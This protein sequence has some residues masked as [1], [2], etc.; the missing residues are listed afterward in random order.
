M[1]TDLLL[2]VEVAVDLIT[3]REPGGRPAE[4]AVQLASAEDVRLWLYVG[5]VS[6]LEQ[7]TRQA[8]RNGKAAQGESGDGAGADRQARQA[9]D[10]LSKKVSWLAALSGEGPVFAAHEPPCQAQLLRA[11]ERLGDSGRLL[12]RDEAL[13]AA[14]PDRTM[15]PEGFLLQGAGG[16]APLPFIDLA[17]QQDRLRPELEENLHRVLHHGRYILGQEVAELE[18]RLADFA[19]VER[20]IGCASGTDA[21]LLALLAL[22]VGPGDAVF[23]SPFTF[24]AT[25]EV[26]SLLGA[27][28]VFVDIDPATLTI[29][30]EQLS[31]AVRSLLNPEEADYPLPQGNRP[32]KPKAVIPVD[33]FGVPAD[34]EGIRRTAEAFGLQI[35]EDAAQSLGAEYHGRKAGALADIGCTSFFP[36]KPLGAYGDA[37]A[38]FTDDPE[39][40]AVMDSLKVHGTGSERYAHD[41][42]GLNARLDSLQ[43]AV[44]LPKL[45]ILQE[46]VDSRQRVAATYSRLIRERE[47]PL[48]LPSVP[49]GCRSAWAQYSVLAQDRDSR[50]RMQKRLAEHSVPSAI[51]YPRPLHMQR[52]FA[53]LGYRPED[54]PVSL[55]MSSRIFSLP[56]HPYLDEPGLLRIVSALEG[57]PAV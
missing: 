30:P 29:D 56:M 6:R 18:R 45:D 25:A 38:V 24:I 57:S 32:L 33:L 7:E 15:S 16:K 49:E 17:S 51:Y 22:D 36:A 2:D 3:G 43:A 23:T 13:L 27:T 12:T 28:P 1:I 5:S 37:G 10:A 35:I 42:I 41:R 20:A 4:K 14:H 53:A 52:A 39:L 19:G 26:I 40:A 48:T 47:L 50:E 9:L 55:D 54:M 31:R 11:L 34:Y 46:E 8:L 44:L 21:L